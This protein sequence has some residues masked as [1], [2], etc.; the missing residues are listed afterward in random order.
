[1]ERNEYEKI[2]PNYCKSCK[3][4]GMFKKISPDVYIW[5]CDCIKNRQ[6][7]RCGEVNTLDRMDSCSKCGWHRDDNE[8][9]L[10]GSMVI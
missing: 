3:G 2:Y 7:P 8:R 1:M 10:P 6:C 9:G 5:D 4:W